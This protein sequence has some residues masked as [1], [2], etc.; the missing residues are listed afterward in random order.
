M[1]WQFTPYFLPLICSAAIS[2]AIAV[3]SWRHRAS[4]ENIPLAFLMLAAAIWSGAY[5]LELSSTELSLKLFFTGIEYIGIA[6]LPLTWLALALQFS[7][8]ESL[9]SYKKFWPLAIIPFSTILLVWT[10]D[11]HHL[12]Y[13]QTWI[14]FSNGYPAIDFVQGNWYWINVA[15]SYILIF[16]ATLLV[17]LAFIRSPRLYKNQAL[18][19]LIGAMI[20]WLA[21][22]AY[23]TGWHP[24]PFLDTTPLAF[25]LTGICTAVGLL[26]FRLLDI[27]PVAKD[28][29]IENIPEGII[30]L[31]SKNRILDMNNAALITTGLKLEEA[32][33]QAATIL[34]SDL[35]AKAEIVMSSEAGHAEVYLRGPAEK[36]GDQK[37]DFRC[38][39]LSSS[40]V[41]GR[42]RDL[43]ARILVVQDITSQKKEEAAL[44]ES[45]E[46]ALTL[47]NAP[48]DAAYLLDSSGRILALSQAGA[49]SL[50]GKAESLKGEYAFDLFPP[51]L[52]KSRKKSVC[53]IFRSGQ[54]VYFEDEKDGRY[55]SNSVLPIFGKNGKVV[56]AAIFAKEITARYQAEEAIRQKDSLLA[57]IAVGTNLLLTEPNLDQAIDQTLEI[58]GTIAGAD[59]ICIY[60]NRNGNDGG[61]FATLM[62]KWFKE[63]SLCKNDPQDAQ[64]WP[65]HPDMTRWYQMLSEGRPLIGSVRD[66]PASERRILDQ[67]GI[68]SLLA[69]PISTNDLFWGFISFN[70]C[71]SKRL[72]TGIN[73]SILQAFAASL[74]AAIIRRRAEDSLRKA[75]KEAESAVK[76]KSNFLASM[77]HEIRTPLNAVIGLTSLLQRTDLTE[78]QQEYVDT[79]RNSGNSLLSAINNILDFSKMDNGK[80]RLEE[81]PFDLK[82]CIKESIDLVSAH[83]SEKGLEISFNMDP[84]TPQ[85]I[86]GDSARLRQTLVNLLSNAVKFTDKGKVTVSTN[87]RRQDGGD[88]E[89]HF[90]VEDTGIGI[91]QEGMGSLFQSFSQID[92]SISRKYGGT[93][94]GLAI[95]KR[96]VEF[97]GGRIW[98]ESDP[99]KGSIFHF[100]IIVKAAQRNQ[101]ISLKSHEQSLS[102]PLKDRQRPIKVLLAEDNLINQ[103]VAL[104]MLRKIGLEADLAANGQEVLSALEHELYDLVLMDVQMPEMDGIEAAKRIREKWPKVPKIIALTAFALEGDREK[105]IEA[106]M[107]DY[108]SKPIQIQELQNKITSV[109]H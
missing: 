31:D 104:K 100:T 18:L 62:Y 36:G 99:G 25:V 27:I 94:L 70:D 80:M 15:Y 38:Y 32:I 83:A 19:L 51:E 30:V 75:K 14:E 106:G 50:G 56:K 47:L 33:G 3:Y 90:S 11:Y 53:E 85:T 82:S 42:N 60:E 61:Q 74:G 77:S 71:H 46:T 29:V 54:P 13:K 87:S 76:S 4:S 34:P 103:K 28:I 20:P 49:Q 12:I 9:L 92:P 57:A 107:D 45:E 84:S 5:A 65:Y 41:W 78:E 86:L 63:E 93:G 68:L 59:A 43:K 35:L 79:I 37:G 1:T 88:Y 102:I 69:I 66:F 91:A 16:I 8:Y 58:I 26:H 89:I 97:M 109:L 22:L 108:I 73:A 55:F 23:M 52:R 40:P 98:A 64:E 81:R 105:C 96:L 48:L 7:G 24:I 44:R 72:W 2:S 17:I 101:I 67:K 39:S 6:L 21:N 95:S 10:N